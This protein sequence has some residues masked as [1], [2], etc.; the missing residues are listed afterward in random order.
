MVL[1]Q[2]PSAAAL[3]A[4]PAGPPTAAAVASS[5]TGKRAGDSRVPPGASKRPSSKRAP[6]TTSAGEVFLEGSVVSLSPSSFCAVSVT[7]ESNTGRTCNSSNH[8]SRKKR[9]AKRARE[10]SSKPLFVEGSFLVLRIWDGSTLRKALAR[11]WPLRLSG[12]P[13]SCIAMQETRDPP[14]RSIGGLPGNSC[15]IQLCMPAAHAYSLLL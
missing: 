2:R 10:S 8:G 11:V 4:T 5:V 3:Q 13:P 9:S 1:L 12:C 14:H 6:G 7:S 15:S